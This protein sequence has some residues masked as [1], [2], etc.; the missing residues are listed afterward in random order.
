M[1]EMTV[2]WILSLAASYTVLLV[3]CVLLNYCCGELDEPIQIE[4][5]EMV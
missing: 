3:I 5:E 4:M 1:S 2:V